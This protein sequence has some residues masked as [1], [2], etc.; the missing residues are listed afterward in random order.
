MNNVAAYFLRCTALTAV[1][2]LFPG[3]LFAAGP[4]WIDADPACD[5]HSAHDVDDCWALTLALYALPE[6]IRG[7]STVF[8]NSSEAQSYGSMQSVLSMADQAGQAPPVYRGA[9]GPLLLE[10]PAQHNAAAMAMAAALA[11]QMLTII[12]LGPLTNI[13]A[14]LQAHPE[15]GANIERVIAVAGQRSLTDARFYPGSSKLF[16]VHDF[17]FRKDVA[18]FETVLRAGIPMTLLPF[19]T[20]QKIGIGRKDLSA[21]A[22][23]SS[24]AQWLARVSGPWLTFWE[25]AFEAETFHPF[26]S[27]AV[28]IVIHPSQFSCEQLPVII[29]RKPAL[30]IDSR[31]RLLVS[32]ALNS[33]FS[34]RYCQHV[35]PEFKDFLL[36]S[37]QR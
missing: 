11:E 15:Q 22:V 12:A 20:A 14:L 8:G 37:L 9:T 27:L 17:N 32:S 28:G 19:E 5:Y 36:T 31:D 30:F 3:Y 2:C 4:V 35:D 6:H 10:A 34:V 29:E 21:M 16:H 1:C 26:D 25:S 24:T 13:A 18:A 33:Q 23:S 7:F